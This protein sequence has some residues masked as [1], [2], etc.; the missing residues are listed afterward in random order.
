MAMADCKSKSYEPKKKEVYE[1]SG[2]LT[3]HQ[4]RS[5]AD[6]KRSIQEFT[7]KRREILLLN[8]SI[9]NQQE[10]IDNLHK[11]LQNKENG[12]NRREAKLLKDE[13]SFKKLQRDAGIRW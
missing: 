5:S 2:I 12:I 9:Q 10:Q 3:R 8:I 11:D 7:S 1:S 4:D 6:D 13:D